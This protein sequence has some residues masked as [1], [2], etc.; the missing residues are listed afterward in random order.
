MAMYESMSKS[1]LSSQVIK[2]LTGYFIRHNYH[3]SL[4][5]ANESRPTGTQCNVQAHHYTTASIIK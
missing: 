2:N 5:T 1:T 4:C 3:M